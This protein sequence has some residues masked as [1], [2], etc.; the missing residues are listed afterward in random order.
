MALVNVLKNCFCQQ[1]AEAVRQVVAHTIDQLHLCAANSPRGVR[2]A[3]RWQ[4]RIIFA[5]HYQR[6]ARDPLQNAWS[7]TVGNDRGQ[8]AHDSAGLET[9]SDRI[10]QLSSDDIPG[11]RIGGAADHFDDVGKVIQ[12]PIGMLR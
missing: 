12:K 8:L 5:V 3:G 2:T 11:R 6:R 4:E 1:W 7:V 10:C 9:S